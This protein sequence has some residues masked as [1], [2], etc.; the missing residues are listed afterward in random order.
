[1]DDQAPEQALR[2]DDNMSFPTIDLFEGVE[3]ADSAHSRRR[4]RLAVDN[5]GTWFSVPPGSAPDRPR[6]NAQKALD[7]SL[8]SPSTEVVIHGLP[9]RKFSGQHPPLRSSF[10]HIQH[11]VQHV[12]PEMVTPFATGCKIAADLV[13]LGVRHVGVVALLA[14]GS[15]ESFSEKIADSS[16]K[17]GGLPSVFGDR[18]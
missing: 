3:A 8:L 13:P 2:I 1:M 14:H 9:R 10:D 12:V 11:R 18:C 15:G 7:S 4:N 17:R 5:Q 6:R 16:R